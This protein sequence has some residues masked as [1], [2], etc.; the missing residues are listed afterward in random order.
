M[1]GIIGKMNHQFLSYLLHSV[2]M[3]PLLVGG[4]R[5][6]L[7]A[8]VLM[9]IEVQLP[10]IKEQNQLGDLFTHLDT[11]IT[12]HQRKQLTNKMKYTYKKGKWNVN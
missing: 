1:Q 9:N 4:G 11:L 5:A 6:K 7:N 10:D 3:E 2:D 8:D 12:L